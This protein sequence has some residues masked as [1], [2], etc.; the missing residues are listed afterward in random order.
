MGNY[1]ISFERTT[2]GA[3]YHIELRARSE[4]NATKRAIRMATD[5]L[6]HTSTVLV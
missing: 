5:N 4:S 1:R 3:G 6:V 2:D